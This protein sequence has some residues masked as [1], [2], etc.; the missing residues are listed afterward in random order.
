MSGPNLILSLKAAVVAVTLIFLCSL[1]ALA[2]GRYRLHGR[3][4]TAFFV[5]AFVALFGLEVMARFVDPRLFDYFDAPAR[6]ALAVHLA[7]SVPAAALL[8]VMLF[9]GL[10]RR[11]GYHLALAGVF[12]VFWTGTFITGVFFLPHGRP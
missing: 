9:T 6:R 4:N 2:A 1:V 10:T 12:G 7:F 5:L 3:L 8:P 11:R